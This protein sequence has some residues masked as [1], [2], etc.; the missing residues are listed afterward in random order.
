MKSLFREAETLTNM[1]LLS[2]DFFLV[3]PRNPLFFLMRVK[4]DGFG[5]DFFPYVMVRGRRIALHCLLYLWKVPKGGREEGSQ[6]A[7]KIGTKLP[8]SYSQQGLWGIAPRKASGEWG[9]VAGF[10]IRGWRIS[11][12]VLCNYNFFFFFFHGF[13]R[14]SRSSQQNIQRKL[15][16]LLNKT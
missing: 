3:V 9:K 10:E 4:T 7:W 13:P 16:L 1:L 2:W 12:K 15:W 11:L 14:P 8:A 5:S 6:G